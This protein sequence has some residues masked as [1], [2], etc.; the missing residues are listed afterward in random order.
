MINIEILL[1]EESRNASSK[2]IVQAKLH[3]LGFEITGILSASISAKISEAHFVKVFGRSA[4][5]EDP[6]PLA[7][8]DFGSLGG[9]AGQ[10]LPLPPGLDQYVESMTIPPPVTLF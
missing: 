2:A 9:Y 1:R 10:E 5:A 6:R 8:S 3:E 4:Q 7:A